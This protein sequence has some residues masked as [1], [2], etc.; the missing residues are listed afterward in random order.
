MKQRISLPLESDIIVS[1]GVPKYDRRLSDKILGAL[2]HAYAEG[3][4]VLAAT[5]RKALVEAERIIAAESDLRI[6][7]AALVQADLWAEFVDARD[8]FRRVSEQ[9]APESPEF[10]QARLDM[11]DSY[12]RWSRS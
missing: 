1:I 8:S 12:M 6:K 10:E 4:A 3:E 2:N 7:P 9:S 5:L 11:T